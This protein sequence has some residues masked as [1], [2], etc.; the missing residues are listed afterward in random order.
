MFDSKNQK[1]Q[2]TYQMK[3][4]TENWEKN[5]TL[6]KFNSPVP[7]TLEFGFSGGS[8]LT[9]EISI[10]FVSQK[11]KNLKM[12][13]G[14]ALLIMSHFWHDEQSLKLFKPVKNDSL[15]SL[16]RKFSSTSGKTLEKIKF[17]TMR[18][19]SRDKLKKRDLFN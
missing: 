15:F 19:R 1:L 2:L 4:I 3:T 12:S 10:S 17:N 11:K 18:L 7:K 14:Q 16:N 9:A 13:Q 5:Q 6:I 8:E